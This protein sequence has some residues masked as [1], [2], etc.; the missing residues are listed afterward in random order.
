MKKNLRIY[1]AALALFAA[2]M[3]H[4]VWSGLNEGSTYHIDVAEALTLP[5]GSLKAVRVFGTVAP[6]SFTRAADSLS[7]IFQLQDQ[8]DPGAVITV[9]YNGAVPEGLKP[10]IELYAEGT[11]AP[12]DKTL[13]ARELTTKCPSKYKKENRS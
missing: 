6:D 7:A 8:R 10:G 3:G 2:G 4:L 9:V 5:E 12:G 13:R 1:L 11:C